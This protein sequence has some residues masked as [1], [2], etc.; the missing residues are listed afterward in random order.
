MLQVATTSQCVTLTSNASGNQ[1]CGAFTSTGDWF[2]LEWLESWAD[3]HITVKKLLPIVIGVVLWGKQ[4]GGKVVSC[5]CDNAAV[6]NI[7]RSG[8]CKNDLAMH[9]LRSLFFCMA[10]TQVVLEAVHIPGK[11]NGPADALSRN[12]LSSFL[13]QV[14]YAQEHP[15]AVLS[16]L[17]ELL[18]THHS[19]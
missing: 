19:D 10:T 8:W 11:L 3:V 12:N 5:C 16:E 6:V 15:A 4:W 13:S 1:G 9:L 7:L 2:F 18:L 14:T 17:I